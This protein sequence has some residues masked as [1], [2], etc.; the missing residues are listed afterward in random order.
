M[1]KYLII[2]DDFTGANDTGVQLTRRGIRTRVVLD[3]SG[4]QS[5]ERSYVID[6]E[7]RNVPEEEAALRVR[8]LLGGVDA[9]AFD[10]VIKKV[11]STLR[12]NIAR[13]I[14]ETDCAYKSG[15]VI[16]MPALPSL[17]RCTVGG[18][19]RLNGVRILD[20]ELA[21]DPRKPVTEDRPAE[22]LKAVYAEPV[23]ELGL[24]DIRSG[25][26]DLSSC[27]VWACDAETDE[28]MQTVI[29][30]AKA[31]AER[32]LWVGTAAIADN[33]TE[34]ESRSLP[35]FALVTSVSN[36]MR[37]QLGYAGE[38][39]LSIVQ[40][41]AV[42][43]LHGDDGSAC[44]EEVCA[45]LRGGKNAALVS[46]ASCRREN[47]DETLAAGAALGLSA[48]EVADRVCTA[49]TALSAQVLDREP[50][51][52]L[53]ISGGDTAIHFFE[54]VGAHGSEICSEVSIGV[55]MMRLVGGRFDGM[56]AV[57]KAGA[58]GSEDLLPAVMRK[59]CEA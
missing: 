48:D 5:D 47:L 56:K 39:G 6:T 8:G 22:L 25:T 14:Y 34:L 32:I 33:L 52:G 36:T 30:A 10:C 18:I 55:P 38:R 43:L 53:F 21:K 44:V 50:V 37:T 45:L 42:R 3:G 9:G 57:T 29:R 11:D 26:V 2:A 15:L 46:S 58:F 41:D 16:F 49:V 13:E 24:S 28:D 17:G 4:V 12:G 23:G 51:S 20:T 1:K 27:R 35:A 54:Q 19:H 31:A 59:L 40:V 7:S